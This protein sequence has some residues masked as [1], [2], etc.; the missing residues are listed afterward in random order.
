[1]RGGDN[2][3]VLINSYIFITESLLLGVMVSQLHTVTVELAYWETHTSVITHISVTCK[4]RSCPI[5]FEY[6]Q[7][8]RSAAY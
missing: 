1:M 2:E 4:M 6:V 5:A 7:Y 8:Y 3:Q